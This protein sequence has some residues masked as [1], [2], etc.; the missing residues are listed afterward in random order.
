MAVNTYSVQGNNGYPFGTVRI[1][2][3]LYSIMQPF[4]DCLW[5]V[6]ESGKTTEIRLS[7]EERNS[8]NMGKAQVETFADALASIIEHA[9]EEWNDETV[10]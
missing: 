4:F 10:Q 3:R 9:K 7:M 8:L 1:K 6:S 5:L 2:D